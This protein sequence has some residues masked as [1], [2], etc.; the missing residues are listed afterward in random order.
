MV[1]LLFALFA[2]TITATPKGECQVKALY[3]ECVS[4]ISGDMAVAALL[5]LGADEAALR[6]GLKGLE[7]P[8]Y[9]L[10]IARVVKSGISACDFRVA[11]HGRG[12]GHRHGGLA[13][14]TEIIEGSAISRRAKATAKRA[15]RIMAEAEAEVHGMPPGDVRFHEIGEVDSI[16]DVVGAAICLDDLDIGRVYCTAL[17]EGQGTVRCAHG[18]LPVPAPATL[19]IARAHGI[20][21]IITDNEGEMV[22]P[23]GIAIAAAIASQFSPPPCATI[24]KIGYGAGKRAYKRTN[25]LRASII[26]ETGIPIADI[27]KE[28][29]R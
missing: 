4:G 11:P 13:E 1:A 24:R 25:L 17:R 14:I 20:P 19:E 10:E 15:F 3:L 26:E 27:Y 23:T 16:L 2:Q 8:G 28:E 29:P 22:T 18:L 21:L 6:E 9:D 12:H 7:L 5:D